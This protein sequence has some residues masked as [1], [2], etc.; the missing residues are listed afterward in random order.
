MST[1]HRGRSVHPGNP[2]SVGFKRSTPQA[3]QESTLRVIVTVRRDCLVRGALT[4]DSISSSLHIACSVRASLS[5]LL[6]P[7]SGNRLVQ[8][9][10]RGE[11]EWLQRP[12][13]I[14]RRPTHHVVSGQ[15][16][17]NP[18]PIV[19]RTIEH[20]PRLTAVL[21]LPA[22]APR[23]ERRMSAPVILARRDGTRA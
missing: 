10:A 22:G 12:I 14:H 15:L 5:S 13:P 18:Q 6:E 21:S 8:Q 2:K 9:R 19:T 3:V 1:L 20:S 23:T 11:R 16:A 4:P 7:A 17:L